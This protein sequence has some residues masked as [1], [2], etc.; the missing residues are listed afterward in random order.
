M[1]NS[2]NIQI[3]AKA[4]EFANGTNGYAV[5]VSGIDN[6]LNL[7]MRFLSPLKAMRYMFLISKRHHIKINRTDLDNI[8]EQYAKSK[9]SETVEAQ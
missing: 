2:S 5:S 1:K 8:K 6:R 3:I 9:K 4:A 7:S